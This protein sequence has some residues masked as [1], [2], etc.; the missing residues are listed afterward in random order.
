M[1][2]DHDEI[3]LDAYFEDYFK[4]QESILSR[5]N[6]T[7]KEKPKKHIPSVFVKKEKKNDN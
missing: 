4:F 5:V 1:I 2:Y 3:D 6:N 7:I